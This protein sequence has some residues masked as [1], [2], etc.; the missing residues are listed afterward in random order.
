MEPVSRN[1]PL[2]TN[3]EPVSE[4]RNNGKTTPEAPA[5]VAKAEPESV[6]V[7]EM[8]FKIPAHVLPNWE[9]RRRIFQTAMSAISDAKSTV[10]EL[11]ESEDGKKA[12]A[13]QT[14][15]DAR[16]DLAQVYRHVSEC[17]P[18]VV[19]LE[20]SGESVRSGTP[21]KMCGRSGVQGRTRLEGF[22]ALL[23]ARIRKHKLEPFKIGGST[24][25]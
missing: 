9:L 13:H 5:R 19:C 16:E 17:K 2:T 10:V 23:E 25:K 4:V 21:C 14:L 1:Q 15:Q 8:G 20:C 11:M 7:D 12:H 22:P 3:S 24:F 6:P 18:I